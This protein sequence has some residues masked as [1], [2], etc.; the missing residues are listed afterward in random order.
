MAFRSG[1]SRASVRPAVA[2][3]IHTEP[4]CQARVPA[5]SPIGTERAS[6]HTLGSSRT[7][8]SFCTSLTRELGMLPRA[9]FAIPYWGTAAGGLYPSPVVLT[10][11]S[12]KTTVG[13][14]KGRTG[15]GKTDLPGS[16]GGLWKRGDEACRTETHW[17]TDGFA[18]VP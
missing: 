13:W 18:T 14:T 8:A 7:K 6:F 5:P 1:G 15:Y 3:C 11:L 10:L 16:Q 9:P 12:G 2:C 17:E 4:R